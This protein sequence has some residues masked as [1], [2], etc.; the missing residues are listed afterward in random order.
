MRNLPGECDDK[1]TGANAMGIRMR[2]TFLISEQAKKR[3]IKLK[4]ELDVRCPFFK[5]ILTPS[6]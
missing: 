6:F 3:M 2:I 5:V 4:T 1:G